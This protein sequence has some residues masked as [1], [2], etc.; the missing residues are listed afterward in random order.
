MRE[1]AGETIKWLLSQPSICIHDDIP[2]I[3]E[4]RIGRNQLELIQSIRCRNIDRV[5]SILQEENYLCINARD[6]VC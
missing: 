1:S 6:E 2:C 3:K 5:I 4:N